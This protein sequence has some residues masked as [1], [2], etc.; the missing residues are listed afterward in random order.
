MSNPLRTAMFAILALGAA[1]HCLAKETYRCNGSIKQVF[2]ITD[3]IGTWTNVSAGYI[4]DGTNAKGQVLCTAAERLAHPAGTTWAELA[5]PN[6]NPNAGSGGRFGTNRN[7]SVRG[8]SP[9]LSKDANASPYM[10]LR[11]VPEGLSVLS[12][13]KAGEASLMKPGSSLLPG[14][15]LCFCSDTDTCVSCQNAKDCTACCQGAQK[16]VSRTAR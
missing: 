12:I 3:G 14:S 6:E 15:V 5:R 16:A 2:V 4:G 7:V 8:T 9:T 13:N 10:P 1:S 11:A